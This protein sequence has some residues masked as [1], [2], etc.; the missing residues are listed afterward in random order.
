MSC[1]Q[2][3]RAY[4]KIKSKWRIKIET[5]QSPPQLRLPINIAAHAAGA[6]AKAA[7]ADAGGRADDVRFVV[8]A[9]TNPLPS[10]TRTCGRW[11]VLSP[12]AERSFQVELPGIALNTK[13]CSR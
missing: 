5:N 3:Q 10:I 11:G 13:G 8:S 7:P 12:R 2:Y 6:K 1:A 9:L 4:G